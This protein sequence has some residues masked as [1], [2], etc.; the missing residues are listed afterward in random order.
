MEQINNLLRE[1]GCEPG[2][3]ACP[4]ACILVVSELT[5]PSMRIT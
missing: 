1:T 5:M 4:L 2:N 3:C